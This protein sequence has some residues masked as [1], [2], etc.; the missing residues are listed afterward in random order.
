MRYTNSGVSFEN[1][2]NFLVGILLNQVR[3]ALGHVHLVS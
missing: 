2:D 1:F 3:A